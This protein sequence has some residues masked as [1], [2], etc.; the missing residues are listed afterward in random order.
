MFFIFF[1]CW[2]PIR[3]Y[4]INLIFTFCSPSSL[5]SKKSNELLMG[6]LSSLKSAASSMAKKIDEIKEAIS[7]NA[8]P[9]KDG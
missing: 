1:Y 5:T 4:V 6:G 2:Y 8:T 9:L 3:V 7:A